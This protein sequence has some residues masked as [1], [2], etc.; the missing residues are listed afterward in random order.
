MHSEIRYEHAFLFWRLLHHDRDLG[1]L[2]LEVVI[3]VVQEDLFPFLKIPHC[4]I[5]S[6][7][8]L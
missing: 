4:R 2:F 7:P 3:A 1:N 8:G 6:V 5:I